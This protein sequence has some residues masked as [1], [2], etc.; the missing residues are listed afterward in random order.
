MFQKM[1]TN[2]PQSRAP[3]PCTKTGTTI[4]RKAGRKAAGRTTEATRVRAK[5]RTKVAS[6]TTRSR[7]QTTNGLRR[8]MCTVTFATAFTEM[9]VSWTR[10][11]SCT[12]VTIWTRANLKLAVPLRLPRPPPHLRRGVSAG[13]EAS[14]EEVD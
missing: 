8:T 4:R 12:K 7:S 9:L 11:S 10:R 3:T 13:E 5:A 6:P 14:A 2:R 1:A